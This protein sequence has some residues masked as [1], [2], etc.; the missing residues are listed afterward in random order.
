MTTIG[1]LFFA[2]LDKH[3]DDKA[4]V[5]AEVDAALDQALRQSVY[6]HGLDCHYNDYRRRWQRRDRERPQRQ[7]ARV[8]AAY[9]FPITKK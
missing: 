6:L 5:I 8:F 7:P 2:A 9:E 3:R 4:A 1:D